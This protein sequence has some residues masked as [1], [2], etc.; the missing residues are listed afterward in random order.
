MFSDDI[1]ELCEDLQLYTLKGTIMHRQGL[2]QELD[3]T[4][5]F[6]IKN[7]GNKAINPRNGKRQRYITINRIA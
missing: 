4:G 6:V 1:Q 5:K 3:K 7:T 2:I